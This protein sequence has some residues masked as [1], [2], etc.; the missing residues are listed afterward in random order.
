MFFHTGQKITKSLDSFWMKICFQKTS[1]IAQSG[2]AGPQ[3]VQTVLCYEQ[4][5]DKTMHTKSWIQKAKNLVQ[6]MSKIFTNW[7][8]TLPAPLPSKNLR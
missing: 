8:T 6:I 5:C 1:K 4:K 2:H 7:L 3:K